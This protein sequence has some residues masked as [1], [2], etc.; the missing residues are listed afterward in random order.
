MKVVVSGWTTPYLDPACL[1]AEGLTQRTRKFRPDNLLT[2]DH[3]YY[4]ESIGG[5]VP[6]RRSER[7]ELYRIE[8]RLVDIRPKNMRKIVFSTGH[9]L[10]DA[11]YSQN[12]R[13]YVGK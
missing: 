4:R 12:N 7:R 10:S 3:S 9:E 1:Q 11:I 13:L 6:W 2:L 8:Q 5:V